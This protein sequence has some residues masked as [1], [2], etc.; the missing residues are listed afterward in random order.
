VFLF[1]AKIVKK[2]NEM[3]ILTNIRFAK[4]AGIAQTLSSFINFIE[5]KRSCGIKIVGV[6]LSNTETI[7]KQEGSFSLISQKI[8]APLVLDAIKSSTTIDELINLFQPL[9]QAY[10]NVIAQEK[11]DVILINGTY[12]LPWCLLHASKNFNIPAIV[13]Y[14]G[15]MTKE[16]AH[17]K[18]EVHRELFFNMERQ[19]DNPNIFYIFPSNLAKTVVEKEIF[20][21]S[22][23]KCTVL[24]NPVPAY[25][26]KAKPPKGIRKHIGVVGRWTKIKNPNFVKRLARYNAKH[27]NN[28]SLNVVSDIS[29]RSLACRE[30][31]GLACFK[32]PMNN[33]KLSKFYASMG[34]VISPSHFE[35]YGNVAKEAL[36][37]GVPALISPQ[38]GVAET[39]KD[40]GL[41]DWIIDFRSVRKVFSKIKDVSSQ[42]V[43]ASVREQLKDKYS[44]EIIH[45]KMVDI[46]RSV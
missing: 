35:T 39:F 8:E 28:Y 22:I 30:L 23:K 10:K 36:A 46:I 9:V 1:A 5:Q 18:N 25:F 41:D 43:P 12:Y 6:D 14:H 44:P 29:Q 21:H 38:M 20:G 45:D 16:T 4:L 24:P 19:F 31:N 15:S 17:W 7:K 3:K 11:P 2:G 26:F 37:S 40:L 32:S 42:T 33:I 27:G 13:H 34:V